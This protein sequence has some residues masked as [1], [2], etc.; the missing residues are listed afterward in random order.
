[1][2]GCSVVCGHLAFSQSLWLK[3]A[4]GV[5]SSNYESSKNVKR[6]I[7][8]HFLAIHAS[9]FTLDLFGNAHTQIPKCKKNQSLTL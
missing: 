5:L 6:R 4:N 1:M 9:E 8:S 2:Y 3:K 7:D